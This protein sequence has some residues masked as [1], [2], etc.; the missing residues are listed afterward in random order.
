MGSSLT[1]LFEAVAREEREALDQV[2]FTPHRRRFL[3]YARGRR[4]RRKT[5]G[6]V[7]VGALAM[8]LVLGVYVTLATRPLTFD[9]E[10]RPGHV[11]AFLAAPERSALD[12]DFS[13]GSHLRLK[14]LG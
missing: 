4:L 1:D 5:L 3:K 12:V 13:D 7:G 9:V 10:G 2:D 14:Q 11:G 8:S 6:W